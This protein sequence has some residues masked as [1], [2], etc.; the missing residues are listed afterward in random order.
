MLK[1]LWVFG[2][3]MNYKRKR[4]NAA[5]WLKEIKH[6]HMTH[7]FQGKSSF[8]HP[9]LAQLAFP[10]SPC[11]YEWHHHPP[12]SQAKTLDAK[13]D[14]FFS[15]TLLIMISL[16]SPMD[17]STPNTHD[18][19][20]QCCYSDRRPTAPLLIWNVMCSKSQ[21]K[22]CAMFLRSW[23][24]KCLFMVCFHW[25]GTCHVERAVQAQSE[26]E[27]WQGDRKGHDT[28]EWWLKVQHDYSIGCE[29]KDSGGKE[30]WGSGSSRQVQWC[31]LQTLGHRLQAFLIMHPI[32][33]FWVSLQI[34]YS[35]M[36]DSHMEY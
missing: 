11:L 33:N 14:F 21:G 6:R 1:E 34:L 22:I 5:N 4:D 19:C 3:R 23:R 20:I 15:L 9:A 27:Q 35:I 17:S 36:V 28:I 13:L 12:S 10:A 24:G 18:I 29:G 2:Y 32:K 25:E 16:K 7:L 26:E 30:I 8:T 31:G